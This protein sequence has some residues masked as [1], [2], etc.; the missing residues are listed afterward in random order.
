MEVLRGKS[1]LATEVRRPRGLAFRGS[2]PEWD[3]MTEYER[4]FERHSSASSFRGR[5]RT[6][7][8][9]AAGV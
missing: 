5:F 3:S 8:A 9:A 2:S 4:Y 7:S 1:R 6:V